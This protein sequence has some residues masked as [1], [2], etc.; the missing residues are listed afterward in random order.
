MLWEDTGCC[1]M[2]ILLTLSKD[3]W[4]VDSELAMYRQENDYSGQRKVDGKWMK[5]DFLING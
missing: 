3:Y 5:N 4:C 1:A 2:L